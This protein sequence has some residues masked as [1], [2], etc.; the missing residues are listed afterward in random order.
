M[1]DETQEAA[2]QSSEQAADFAALQAAAGPGPDEVAAEEQ[3]EQGRHDLGAEIE[4][5]LQMA[6]GMLAP[7][8]PS[9]PGIY[10]PEAT[11]AASAAVAGVCNKH[12]WMQGGMMGRY[13]EE[14]ACALIVGPMAFATY[15]GVK[16]DIAAR[17]PVERIG[18]PDL[19]APVPVS[20][21]APS[22][23][24]TFGAPVPAPASGAVAA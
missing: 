10:T 4:G 2:E 9:L 15:K 20:G 5:L 17:Q 14:I 18:G 24:V 1:R 22:K 23:V 7:M 12:G 11:Q 8:F 16:G 13:G 6:V 21:P 3:Q 19:S